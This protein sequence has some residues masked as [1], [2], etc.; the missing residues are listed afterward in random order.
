MKKLSYSCDLCSAV[1][2]DINGFSVKC[3]QMPWTVEELGKGRYDFCAFCLSNLQEIIPKICG[4]G[5]ECA[6]GP[7]CGSSH[8]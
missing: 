3:D 7:Y 1:I 2:N 5:F 8:K 4:G 6:G